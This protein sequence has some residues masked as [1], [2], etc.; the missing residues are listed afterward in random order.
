MAIIYFRFCFQLQKIYGLLMYK[1]VNI[2]SAGH[3]GTKYL[4]QCVSLQ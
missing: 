3:G 4:N 2:N 1:S